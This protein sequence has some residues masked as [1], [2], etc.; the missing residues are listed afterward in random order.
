MKWHASYLVLSL[1]QFV[2]LFAKD[3]LNMSSACYPSRDEECT[4]EQP[5]ENEAQLRS[6]AIV[7]FL[8][9]PQDEA[10]GEAQ[11]SA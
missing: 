2:I 5:G 9:P 1:L 4:T 3:N 11:D 6:G 7:V 10:V 8:E